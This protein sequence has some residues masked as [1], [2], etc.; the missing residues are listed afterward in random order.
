LLY[1]GTET[2]LYLSFDDGASWTRMESNLP[3]APIYDLLIKEDDLVVATHGR[4][5][6]ILDDVSALRAMSAAVS[7]QKAHLFTPRPAV[8]IPPHLT[9]SWSGGSPG[10]NYSPTSGAVA[11]FYET[12]MPEGHKVR[13][14]LDGGEDRPRGVAFTYYLQSVPSEEV[15]LI[16]QDEQG[17]LIKAFSSQKSMVA[18]TNHDDDG[19]KVPRLPLKAGLNRF[20]WDMRYPDAETVP[21]DS[22]GVGGATGPLAKPG[23]YQAHLQLGDETW[24]TTFEIIKDPRLTTAQDAFEAQFDLLMAIRD[25]LSE[26]HRGVKRLRSIRAQVESWGKRAAE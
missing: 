18:K 22:A 12:E 25:K 3:V 23:T 21:G 11:A 17:Q 6:W 5:F 4:A 2:G 20:L 24:T 9:E 14:I 13:I 8:R 16:I 15:K 10:K 26:T 1:A 7:Q 19:P